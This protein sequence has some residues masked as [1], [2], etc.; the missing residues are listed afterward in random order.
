MKKVSKILCTLNVNGQECGCH[1]HQFHIWMVQ[2][3]HSLTTSINISH[4]RILCGREGEGVKLPAH[5]G[6]P[7]GLMC[8]FQWGQRYALKISLAQTTILYDMKKLVI[9]FVQ[10]LTLS[11]IRFRWPHPFQSGKTRLNL[12][13]R[14]HSHSFFSAPFSFAHQKTRKSQ[15]NMRTTKK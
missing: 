13:N 8:N 1:L 6:S 12:W 9:K 5:S 7:L 15:R 3:K 10:K 11:T 14:C 2:S 4:N